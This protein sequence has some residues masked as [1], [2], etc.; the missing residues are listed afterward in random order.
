MKRLGLDPY[1]YYRDDIYTAP[2]G[3][4]AVEKTIKDPNVYPSAVIQSYMR[5][6]FR[7]LAK[8]KRPHGPRSNEKKNMT[9]KYG[10]SK[11]GLIYHNPVPDPPGPLLSLQTD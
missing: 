2:N 6:G 7:R 5:L 11:T 10:S 8:K 1:I 4:P 3:K 9:G